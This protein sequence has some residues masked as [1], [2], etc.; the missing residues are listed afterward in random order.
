MRWTSAHYERIQHLLP[1]QGG[2]VEVDNLV[3]FQALQY[4]TEN[5]CQWRSLPEHFGK[6][7]TIYQRFRRWIDKGV[8]DRIEKELQSESIAIRGIKSLSMDSS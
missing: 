8:F 5:G 2:N 6:W 7:D 4:M 3:F 1:K